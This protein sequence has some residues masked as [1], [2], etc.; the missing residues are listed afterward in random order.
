MIRLGADRLSRGAA[1]SS[2]EDGAFLWHVTDERCVESPERIT[3]AD[4]EE[5]GQRDEH[6][7][8]RAGHTAHRVNQA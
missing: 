7:T 8:E 2:F 4:P 1:P 5:H 3:E 6:E